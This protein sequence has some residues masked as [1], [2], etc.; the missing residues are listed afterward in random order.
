MSKKNIDIIN[1]FFNC[2]SKPGS[3][4]AY[5]IVHDIEKS[6]DPGQVCDWVT[7]EFLKLTTPQMLVIGTHIVGHIFHS[8]AKNNPGEFPQ[9]VFVLSMLNNLKLQQID[10]LLANPA[11]VT[12]N[13]NKPHLH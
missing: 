3:K 7:P 8:I 12:K 10:K 2:M 1:L 5:D 6:V 11:P 9:L 13:E 4:Q